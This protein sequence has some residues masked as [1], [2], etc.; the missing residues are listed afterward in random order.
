MCRAINDSL[1]KSGAIHEAT[2]QLEEM[3]YSL[4]HY[5]EAT[6]LL[7]KGETADSRPRS[8]RTRR[9]RSGSLKL[10]PADLKFLK[11]LKISLKEK[12]RR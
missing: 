1:E 4:A 12:S 3:G 9:I 10:N 8:T 2:R 6:V 5:L 7:T 11:S